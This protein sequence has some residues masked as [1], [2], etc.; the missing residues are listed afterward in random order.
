MDFSMYEKKRPSKFAR[1][2]NIAYS[3]ISF[4]DDLQTAVYNQN[5]K[6][7]YINRP[8]STLFETKTNSMNSV[9]L[10]IKD[11]SVRKIDYFSRSYVPLCG[12]EHV[13]LEGVVPSNKKMHLFK[14]QIDGRDYLL[15]TE[16]RHFIKEVQKYCSDKT[17]NNL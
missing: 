13:I 5:L 15:R 6:Q 8:T 12:L 3:V 2:K 1:V 9:V 10:D 4:F 14:T 17:D 16:D 7:K 11:D